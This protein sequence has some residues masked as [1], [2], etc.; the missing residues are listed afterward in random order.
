[1]NN[2]LRPINTIPNF[3]RFCMT[4][5]ELPTSYLETM[6]YYEMLVWFTEYMKNTIIPTINNNGLAIQ[7][8]QDKYIEL[9]NYVDNYFNNLDVQ[10]E[11]NNKLDAMAQSGQLTDIIAQYLGLAGVLSF[12]TVNDMKTAT[13]LV[14]G[15]TCRTLGYYNINDGGKA[16]YKIRNITNE[17]IV[18]DV[19]II[20]LNDQ[21]LIAELIYDEI[22]T[23]QI[24]CYGDNIH[25]DT[26]KINYVLNKLKLNNGGTLIFSDGI[27]K[28]TQL[29]IDAFNG[30]VVNNITLKSQTK[31]G[32]KLYGSGDNII[33]IKN[34][35]E[36]IIIDGL[37]LY[38]NTTNIGI[39]SNCSVANSIFKNIK[40]ENVYDGI[41]INY[42]HWLL[43][44]SD[45]V[46]KPIHNG[47]YLKTEGTSSSLN[48]IY[49]NGGNGIAYFLGGAYSSASNLACDNFS[50][51]PYEFNYGIWTIESLGCENC[52][53]ENIIKLNE[54]CNVVINNVYIRN[55][56]NATLYMLNLRSYD[57]LIINNF[58]VNSDSQTNLDTQLLTFGNGYDTIQIDKISTLYTT[59]KTDNIEYFSRAGKCTAI[60]EG[61]VYRLWS[62]GNADNPR[63]HV[64]NDDESLNY[65]YGTEKASIIWCE[66]NPKTINGK[67]VQWLTVGK[68][69]K[70]MLKTDFSSNK[71]VFGFVKTNDS[72]SELYRDATLS[73]IPLIYAE[74]TA[75]RPTTDLVIGQ[76]IFDTTLNKPIWY[77]GSNWVDSTG[78]TV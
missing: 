41:N 27:Y 30:N 25:D 31:Y 18:D 57:N 12:N 23:K 49:V 11:I 76:C 54:Y 6:S 58:R 34:H 9:K 71:G 72:T 28:I 36:G 10:Q 63:F 16:I 1:M 68:Q 50:G 70:V 55:L 20:A 61:I 4:I 14:N 22:N 65:Y 29:E 40:I 39:N 78:T 69:G 75:S 64:M 47:L 62:S 3:K 15:S 17:D 19:F 33:L 24:G 56:T 21:L 32:A 60:I 26:S 2:D 7:E 45:I 48:N 66:K 77:N 37:F 53:G 42:S 5:G 43:T 38:G 13:N 44:L 46:I 73:K 59:F 52:T 51:I 35:G 8:L 67:D 74:E